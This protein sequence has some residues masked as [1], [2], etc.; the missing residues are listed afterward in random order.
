[1]WPPVPLT[2]LA[3]L[4][5]SATSGLVWFGGELLVIADDDL[6]LGR[7]GAD[8]SPRGTLELLPGSLPSDAARRK[9]RKPDF[10]ALVVLGE[11]VLVLG[12]GSKNR[13]QV[14]VWVDPARSR[15]VS[16][17][18]APLYEALAGH[19]DR[20][21]VEGAALV[22]G[23]LVLLNRRTGSRGRNLL[24]HLDLCRVAEELG[25]SEP[26]LESDTLLGVFP[27]ELGELE[28]V[29]LGFTDGTAHDD[30]LLFTAAA[31]ATDDPVD[32]GMCKGSVLGWARLDG[33]VV[34][35]RLLD[36][37]AKIEGLCLVPP[38]A[39]GGPELRLVA[40][41]DDPLQPGLLFAAHQP[42]A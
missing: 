24:V 23:R 39:P 37:R 4:R 3:E 5:Q 16:V 17:D 21:N 6:S 35:S 13:R 12:S 29:P 11:R 18:L 32:D 36:T 31:E 28:G 33:S 10:E 19:T 8:G 30:R 41:A 26:A 7:Y 9:R 15:A 25:L 14:G 38:L 34:E 22:G 42:F 40:D 2:T 1:M 27:A 20:V